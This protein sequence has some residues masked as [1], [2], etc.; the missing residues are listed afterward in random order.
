M[1]KD[2]LVDDGAYGSEV[3]VYCAYLKSIPLHT[4]IQY[5]Y[6]TMSDAG[7]TSTPKA[8]LD[9][10][11][12]VVARDVSLYY[13][14]D[15]WGKSPADSFKMAKSPKWQLKPLY[16]QSLVKT[17]LA[18]MPATLLRFDVPSEL[19][20][21]DD[22]CTTRRVLS[23]HNEESCRSSMSWKASDVCHELHRYLES[24][25]VITKENPRIIYRKEAISLVYYCARGSGNHPQGRRT[26]QLLPP[27]GFRETPALTSMNAGCKW[28]I[29]LRYKNCVPKYWPYSR[30]EIDFD[31]TWCKV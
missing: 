3:V 5:R 6:Y 8:F 2:N 1:T 26:I 29:T 17:R 30:A 18:A 25:C 9:C 20:P 28:H 16:D 12:V 7:C 13:T 10:S 24:A 22:E 27:Y 15:F 31:S 4:A 19:Q 23:Y 11:R 14:F 21:V